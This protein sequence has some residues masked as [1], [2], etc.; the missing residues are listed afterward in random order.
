MAAFANFKHEELHGLSGNQLQE[1]LFS[2]KGINWDKFPVWKKRGACILKK[3]YMKEEAVR[4]RWETDLE[5]PVFSKDKDYI[6]R[7]VY[8]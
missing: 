5:I 2:E 6:E 8:L 1:K 4:R 3:E 7:F